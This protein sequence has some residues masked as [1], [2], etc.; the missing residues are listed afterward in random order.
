MG[1]YSDNKIVNSIKETNT[2][3]SRDLVRFEE[4]SK[5]SAKKKDNSISLFYN[6]LDSAWSTFI[7]IINNNPQHLDENTVFNQDTI[8]SRMEFRVDDYKENKVYFLSNLLR[9]LYEYYFWTGTR[10]IVT[11]NFITDSKLTLLENTFKDNESKY[12]F[13]WIRDKLPISLMKW[14][15]N[16]NKLTD[17]RNFISDLDKNKRKFLDDI[18]SNLDMAIDKINKDTEASIS[19]ISANFNDIKKTIVDGKL[20]ADANLK[21]VDESREEIKALEERVRNLKSEYNFVGLSSGFNIIKE[22]K[23][24]ELSTTEMNY[25]NLFGTVFI[26]PVIAVIIHFAFPDLYPKDY[27][28]IF[29]LFPFITIEMAIIYFFRLSYLEAK[30]LRTQLMQI[31]L[32]LSLCAFIDGYVE[33]RRKNNIAIEKVLDSFDALIFSPIQNNENNIP[34]MFDGLEAIAGVAEKVMKK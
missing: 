4:M 3:I 24:K 18:S 29:I 15:L 1:L 16:S 7:S 31:D 10:S 27:S 20:E 23:E 32:R 8:F 30:A 13:A 25:K 12:Q 21:Y 5:K 17:A 26:A 34:A 14:L 33:Y 2:I 19:L 6:T 11:S 28:A 9:V 22:K